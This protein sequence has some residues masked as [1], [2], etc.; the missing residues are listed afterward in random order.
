MAYAIKIARPGAGVRRVL[1]RPLQ[2]V[3]CHQPDD[4][5][6]ERPSAAGGRA[7][8]G[9]VP[10]AHGRPGSS[11]KRF[12][13]CANWASAG[14]AR[15]G[16]SGE[17]RDRSTCLDGPIDVLTKWTGGISGA[18]RG[19]S[20]DGPPSARIRLGVHEADDLG[21]SG[22]CW[23]YQANGGLRTT[24]D[25][26]I[27]RCGNSPFGP[28][29]VD[30]PHHAGASLGTRRW[31][32][33]AVDLAASRG[34]SRATVAVGGPPE[35]DAHQRPSRAAADVDG[36]SRTGR[37]IAFSRF[38]RR[39]GSRWPGAGVKRV[40][41]AAGRPV[42]VNEGRDRLH[43]EPVWPGIGAIRARVDWPGGPPAPC[44]SVRELGCQLV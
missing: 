32:H 7:G 25:R 42:G 2:P 36:G 20:D 14:T 24:C 8:N 43:R 21:S 10:R 28:H 27:R 34:R 37:T 11:P 23:A 1:R 40:V 18:Y 39:D 35:A 3:A 38:V 5:S 29:V 9:T 30:C 44:R 12:R 15:S 13:S 6:R 17:A 26:P 16:C 33:R 41:Q 19:G 4:R 22:G 31:P